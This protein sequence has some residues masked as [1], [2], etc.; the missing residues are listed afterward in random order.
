[1]RRIAALGLAGLGYHSHNH[2]HDAERYR[3]MLP[4]DRE[5]APDVPAVEILAERLGLLGVIDM[6]KRNPAS[7][8]YLP[9]R[10][11]DVDCHETIIVPGA[12]VEAA[13][14]ET[15]G[16]AILA[17][18]QAEADHIAALAQA[19]AAA[20]LQAKLAAGFDPD[21][22]LIE[23]IRSR[24]DLHSVLRGHGYDKEGTKYRHPNSEF[25]LLRR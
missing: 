25:R 2:R 22:S 16:G 7:L 3:L 15:A 24:F 18:R 23:N 5:I 21:D 14:M 9:S 10:P 8:F 17:A 12:P 11:Y 20:R 6:S 4:L 19:E 1:M 13:W